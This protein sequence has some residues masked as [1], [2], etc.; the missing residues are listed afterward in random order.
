MFIDSHE[1]R[2]GGTQRVAMP[3][4]EINKDIAWNTILELS[5]LPTALQLLLLLRDV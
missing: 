3:L 2:L 5:F 4:V 1:R